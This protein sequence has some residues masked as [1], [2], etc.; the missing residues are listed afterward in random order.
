M[1]TIKIRQ[2]V[3]MLENIEIYIKYSNYNIRELF[4]LLSSNKSI[5]KLD[6]IHIILDRINA[7]DEFTNICDDVFKDRKSV[8]NFSLEEID[9]LKG[10]FSCLGQTD[11][12]GQISNCKTYK[13]LF[14]SRLNI[15]EA[16]EKTKCKSQMA[17][18][19]GIGLILSIM[20][21]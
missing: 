3:L 8:S 16:Q 11:I 21:L 17:L 1:H 6:F 2:C 14:K 5:D 12:N 4:N 20:I 19:L 10:F 9:L 18:S 13:E 15:L 7:H